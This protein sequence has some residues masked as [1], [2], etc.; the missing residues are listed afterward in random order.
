M[1]FCKSFQS[2]PPV[3]RLRYLA[4]P[5]TQNRMPETTASAVYE[6]Y[7]APF[8]LLLK[9]GD[10]T[11]RID[12]VRW[13]AGMRGGNRISDRHILISTSDWPDIPGTDPR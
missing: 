2:L 9:P 13:P 5:D 1:R 6:S 7:G 3:E 8:P 10:G 4:C 12:T 11:W